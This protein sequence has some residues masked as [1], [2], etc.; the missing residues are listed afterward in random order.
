VRDPD[1]FR[2]GELQENLATVR[3]LQGRLREQVAQLIEQM[4]SRGVAADPTFQKIFEELP[5]A[6]EDMGEAEVRLGERELQE[7]L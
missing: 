7:E 1:E 3:L 6:A 4:R 5:L 2:G